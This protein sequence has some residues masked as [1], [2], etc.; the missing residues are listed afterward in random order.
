MRDEYGLY[1]DSNHCCS[2]GQEMLPI[3]S[4]NQQQW[5]VCGQYY[6]LSDY[7]GNLTEEGYLN[8]YKDLTLVQDYELDQTLLT[9][10]WICMTFPLENDL[11]KLLNKVKLYVLCS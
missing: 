6:R 10:R 5:C 8:F 7:S 11:D 1:I 2:C 9:S 3:D 4:P